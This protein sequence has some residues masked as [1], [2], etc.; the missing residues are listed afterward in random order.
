MTDMI[1]HP[2]HYKKGGIES[3]DVIEA[4]ELGFC[5]GSAIKYIC[6]LGSKGNKFIGID[7]QLKDLEKARWY[8]TREIEKL[9]I[10]R[11]KMKS[12]CDMDENG[13]TMKN[14]V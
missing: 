6:R 9:T 11:E 12:S 8:I 2:L 1:N 10:V 5:L 13:F 14:I 3:I 7:E 4:W